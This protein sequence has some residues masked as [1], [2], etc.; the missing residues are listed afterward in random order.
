MKD[1]Y[2]YI[3]VG[4]GSSGCIIAARLAEETSGS[5]LLIEAGPAADENPDTMTADGFKYCFANDNVMLDRFSEPQQHMANRSLYQGTGTTM[6]GSGS[7]NGM[8]YTRGDKSDFISWPKGWQWQDN[9]AA[10]EAI[11]EK[12]QPQPR[13][14]TVFTQAAIDAGIKIGMQHKDGLNDGD[15]SGFIGHNAMNYQGDK[16][17]SS[18]MAYLHEKLE[19]K[20]L[21]NLTVLNHC[22]THKVIIE[23]QRA[24][25]VEIER[26]QH[27]TQRMTATKEIILCA[28]ALE[29]PKILM[30]SGIG[31]SEELNKHDIPV[32]LEQNEIGQNLH[33]HPNVCLFY[34]GK[35]K[36]DFAY[37]QLYGFDRVNAQL[38]LA[39]KTQADTCFAFF[40]A[41]ITLHQSMHRML[42]ALAL[43][44]KLYH[45]KALRNIFRTL[46]DLAFKIPALNHHID[47]LYGIVII[48]GKPL[49]RGSLSLQSNNAKDQAVIDTAYYRNPADMQTMINGILQAQKIG[50]Q[51]PLVSWGSKALSAAG[52]TQH[53]KKIEKA[54]KAATMTTFHFCGTCR[55]GED[56]AAPVDTQ[57]RVKGIKDLR[58]ADASV[59]PEIPVSAINAPSMMIAHRCVDF[60]LHH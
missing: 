52:K 7:V 19:N 51:T 35:Q 46:I 42:P 6:G 30:L 37:P 11:E 21:D 23:E 16:R 56:A 18:Y 41:P 28:G 49:S 22:L 8:V 45:I 24:V 57:L 60:I 2:D 32:Q 3:I 5:V 44:K 34:K 31:P 48:L 13:D 1:S 27:T 17:H 14:A 25:A 20:L 55:M 10:F 36:L 53:L 40:A 26:D 12:L 39:S 4:A 29:T 38:P 58:V 9:L 54:I 50:E 33:D 43:P 59:I 15:L 47:R